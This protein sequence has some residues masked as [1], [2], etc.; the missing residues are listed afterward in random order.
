MNFIGKISYG[1]YVY[2][3]IIIYVLSFYINAWLLEV[4]FYEM[5]F[6]VTSLTICVSW[7]SFRFFERPFLKIKNKYSVVK[8]TN[9]NPN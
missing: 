2:H 8:S 6:I 4:N 3:M 5:L 7:L 9:S 1:I